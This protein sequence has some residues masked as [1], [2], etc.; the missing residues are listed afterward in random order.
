MNRQQV[1]DA[2]FPG[3]AW[4]MTELVQIYRRYLFEDYLPFIQRFVFDSKNGGFFCNCN[5]LG[6]RL[7]VSKRTWFDARGAWVY[8]NLYKYYSSDIKYLEMA[9]LTLTLLENAKSNTQPY[10]PWTYDSIGKDL[11]EREGDIYGNLFVAEAYIAYGSAA[12]KSDYQLKGK[13]ILLDAYHHIQLPNYRYKLDYAPDGSTKTVHNVLGHWMILLNVGAGYLEQ[14]SQDVQVSALVDHCIAELMENHF[15]Q[16]SGLLLEVKCDANDNESKIMDDFVY[17]GHAIES[18]WMIMNEA[19][20]KKDKGLVALAK[21]RFKRHVEVAWDDLYGGFFHSL[22]SIDNYR[23][24]MDKVLWAHQEVLI[25]CAI[26]MEKEGDPW[27]YRWFEKTLTYLQRHY[28]LQDLPNRPWRI[29]GDRR[30]KDLQPGTRIE[31]YHH[32]RQLMF[33]LGTLN[34]IL[35]QN[36][37][38][39]DNKQRIN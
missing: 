33:A 36:N 24:L 16:E 2:K 14:N 21:E 20:R 10:W 7:G 9:K 6:E 12:N 8:A 34:R 13:S 28:V 39:H 29:A 11:Q 25:G 4:S 27:A 1:R 38:D 35:D 17:L 30:M 5:Y 22:E 26:L 32:P 18:L 19:Y 23:F 3:G 31:N 15:Q 37:I